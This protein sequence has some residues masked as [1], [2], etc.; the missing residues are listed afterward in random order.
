M[1]LVSYVQK[2]MSVE[3]TER[4][5]EWLEGKQ[6]GNEVL[7]FCLP[8]LTTPT[9]EEIWICFFNFLLNCIKVKLALVK[10]AEHRQHNLP[11]HLRAC[12]ECLWQ[13][14]IVLANQIKVLEVSPRRQ[15]CYFI[16]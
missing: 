3:T 10:E 16:R 4:I 8:H 6:N 9:E 12:A 15:F 5:Y 7:L 2:A 11:S 1:D 14:L 13:K